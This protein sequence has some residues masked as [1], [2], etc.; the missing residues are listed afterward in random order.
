MQ[1]STHRPLLIDRISIASLEGGLEHSAY[2]VCILACRACYQHAAQTGLLRR[3]KKGDKN[4]TMGQCEE[5]QLT[6]SCEV[7]K[8]TRGCQA[9]KTPRVEDNQLVN[10]SYAY[11]NAKSTGHRLG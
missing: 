1:A 4:K 9:D 8:K 5:K 2:V 7:E 6:G 3:W 10:T 11:Y